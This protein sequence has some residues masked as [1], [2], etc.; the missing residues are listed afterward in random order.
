MLASTR[1]QP[2]IEWWMVRE[3]LSGQFWLIDDSL[4]PCACLSLWCFNYSIRSSLI[5]IAHWTWTPAYGWT[6]LAGRRLMMTVLGIVVAWLTTVLPSVILVAT[7][8]SGLEANRLIT[9]HQMS[10]LH[11]LCANI[12]HQVQLKL[13]TQLTKNTLFTFSLFMCLSCRL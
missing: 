13:H 10:M 7:S 4:L 3:C 9:R 5:C 11:S 12:I 2:A 8:G 1:A 6:F